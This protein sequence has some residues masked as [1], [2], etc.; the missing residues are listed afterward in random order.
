MKF[1]TVRNQLAYVVFI[2]ILMAYKTPAASIVVNSSPDT[3]GNTSGGGTYPVGTKVVLTA[4]VTNAC[5]SFTDWSDGSTD[6]PHTITAS[7]DTNYTAY[8]ILN[9]NLIIT[10]SSPT[11]GGTTSGGGWY[12]CGSN[13]ML[14]ATA[15]PC[16]T[17]TN[18]SDGS[19]DN[20]HTII[21]F[22]DASYTATFVQKTFSIQTR[23]AP[24]NS[25]TTTGD[26]TTNCGASVTV[27][28]TPL[29][30]YE[31]VNWTISEMV[32]GAFNHSYHLVQEVKS[33]LPQYTFTVGGNQTLTANF[34]K[35]CKFSIYPTNSAVI[36]VT[37]GGGTVTVSTSAGCDWTYTNPYPWIHITNVTAN[38]L[39]FWSKPLPLAP[40][41]GPGATIV[42]YHVVPFTLQIAGQP[43]IVRQTIEAI[44]HYPIATNIPEQ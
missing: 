20:P 11:S 8:F 15:N 25:G 28:A 21:A 7:S 33:T 14:T 31:F 42:S 10:A 41:S 38:S 3:V 5:W 6:N 26:I 36:P 22:S 19:T 18:W 17:F 24:L 29:A 9:S 16:F 35:P 2:L 13:V 40:E 23:V 43:F 34:L 12:L 32:Y 27:T 30:G 37:G 44:A 39:E 4:T 1:T